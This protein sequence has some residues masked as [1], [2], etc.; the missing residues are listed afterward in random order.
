MYSLREAW[1][2]MYGNLPYEEWEGK[3]YCRVTDAAS[4]FPVNK[5]QGYMAAYSF[6]LVTRGWLTVT[7]SGQKI[8]LRPNDLYIYSPGLEIVVLAASDDYSAICLLADEH[9]TIELPT[10][11]DLVNIAYVPIVRLHEPKITLSDDDAH[12]LKEKMLDIIGYLES[13]HIYKA[14]ILQMLYAVFLLD[15]QS[16]QEKTVDRRRVSQRIEE[17]LIGFIRL[18]PHHFAEHHD[19]GFYASSLNIS[20]VY[21]SRVV[22]KVTG[23]TV[24]DYINRHLL[25]EASYLLRT[26]SLS[27]TQIADRLHFAD[28]PSFSKFFTRN[29]GI[30]PK[31][32]RKMD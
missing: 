24:V 11:H 25:M 19:I 7:Y 21:L 3:M 13:R 23:R 20:P 28:A 18:L 6:T 10:V 30:T 2:I 22:R 32:Y 12:R 14:K 5:T 31:D 15:V 8:T 29:K 17:I 4:T 16:A 9:V 1:I 27:V 26:T